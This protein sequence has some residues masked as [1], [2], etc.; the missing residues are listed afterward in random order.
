MKKT[1]LYNKH[2][3]LGAKIIPF[4][5]F[6]MPVQYEGVNAEHL[7]VRKSVGLFDVSHMGEFFLKGDKATDLLKLICTNDI[8]KIDNEKAQY[9]CL[10]DENGG[11]IDDLIIYKFNA[12]EF[13]LVVNAGNIEKDWNWI[14]MHN[15]N[16]GNILENRSE[17]MSLLALQGPGSYELLQKLVEFDVRSLKNYSFLETDLYKFKN[18]IISTTGYTGS[19]GFEIYCE[20]KD[21]IGIWEILFEFGKE[22]NLKPIGLA[23][24]DTLRLEMGYCLYGNDINENTNPIEAGLKWITKVNKNFIGK[25]QI[26]KT[27]E[28]GPIKKLVGFKLNE[29]GIP[30]HDYKIFNEENTEIGIV[31]S[32]TMS[33][34]LKEG[35]GLG[36][37]HNSY[38]EIDTPIFIEIRNKKVK[39]TVFKLP[40][41]KI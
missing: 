29:R 23:A 28:K 5:G 25:K 33:P 38:S 7:H 12:K 39:A 30:R 11:I 19:G 21:V 20:N 4:S 1:S 24:R 18:V 17:N 37:V 14:K 3:E 22:F 8:S 13:M 41:V 32:G 31:T 6:L 40:F 2:L 27:I 26:V 36:Y 15:K 34:L 16:F 35:I 9:S 10:T